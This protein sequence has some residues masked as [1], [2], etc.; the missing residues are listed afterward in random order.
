MN[1]RSLGLLC[2]INLALLVTLAVITFT[3][4][5]AVAQFGLRG[6]YAMIAGQVTGREPA[7]VYILD[8]KSQRMASVIFDSRNNR[9]EV[10]AGREVS[11][12]LRARHDR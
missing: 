5:P 4:Q 12:D 3:S 10:I 8:L 9:L 11:N 2:A 6:D 7:A 1:K